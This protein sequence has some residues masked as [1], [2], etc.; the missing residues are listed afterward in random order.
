[1]KQLIS[2]VR[3][4]TLELLRDKRTL[5]VV[6][7]MP[8]VLVLLF[9]FAISIELNNLDFVAVA[10]E[11]DNEST[12]IVNSIANNPYF[13]FKGYVAQDDVYDYLRDG[14]AAVALV[15]DHDFEEKMAGVNPGAESPLQV[16]FDAS[17]PNTAMQG[18]NY[19]GSI[20]QER[21]GSY[22]PDTRILYNPQLKSS[23]NFVPGIMGF[24]FILICAQMT[25]VSIVR[26]K[27]TGTMEVLLMS[28]AKTTTIILS[29]MIPNFILC[30]L[31][32]L[33]ILLI[34]RYI[35][36][37]PLAGSIWAI[38]GISLLYIVMSLALGMLISTI[39][40]D[41]VTAIIIAAVGLLV[42]M[43]M[44][45]GMIF[46]IEN[47]PEWL[48]WLSALVPARWYID[49]MRRLMVQGVE[50]S[51]VIKDTVILAVMTVVFLFVALKKFNNRLS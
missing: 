36:G 34:S 38:N 40:Q 10:D 39:A 47:M 9:G 46:P 22:T 21:L 1:M 31:N 29:K 23:Y 35:L 41:Q 27:E 5:L 26:E 3:K 17:N 4:E 44:L 16:L 11:P 32:L 18:V 24:V 7:A 45:S 6:I 13:T 30:A 20:L 43:L 2:F 49:A 51:T 19:L 12:E 28:P 15:F 25:A 42:P 14:K 33:A 37:V 8:A 48:Q 50:F